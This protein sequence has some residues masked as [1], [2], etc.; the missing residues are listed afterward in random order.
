MPCCLQVGAGKYTSYAGAYTPDAAF[1]GTAQFSFLARFKQGSTLPD[2]QYSKL[3]LVLSKKI[4]FASTSFSECATI[5]CV[6]NLIPSPSSPR[7]HS[8]HSR[9]C[10]S[11]AQRRS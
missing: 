7:T 11:P 4:S 1:A 9:T 6:L 5:A 3:S 10:C 2:P 8:T